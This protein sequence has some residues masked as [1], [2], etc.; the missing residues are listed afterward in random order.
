MN[1]LKA[2]VPR[3]LAFVALGAALLIG[4]AW[5]AEPFL[6]APEIGVMGF[7]SWDR[8][9]LLELVDPD[10]FSDAQWRPAEAS[11]RLAVV[12]TAVVLVTLIAKSTRLWRTTNSPDA[13][14]PTPARV[15]QSRLGL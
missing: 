11:A 8:N 2:A 7:E 3:A 10:L 5:V 14:Q 12:L 9:D 15:A 4:F 13:N 1:Q 6:D